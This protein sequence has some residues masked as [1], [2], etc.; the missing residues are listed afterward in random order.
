MLIAETVLSLMLLR[1]A[2][3]RKAEDANIHF[4]SVSETCVIM[5]GEELRTNVIRATVDSMN[6]ALAKDFASIQQVKY[7]FS[8][9]V[10][11][12]LLVWIAIDNAE[13]VVRHRIYEKELALISEFPH[14]SF[15]FNLVN[16]L[17]RSSAELIS[18]AR[19]IYSRSE[20]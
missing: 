16:T 14:I 20:S 7:V 15:D 17:G 1:T 5:Q 9:E 8:E 3:L 11:D 12:A 4:D 2:P 19:I 10:P 6:D 18:G 13:S